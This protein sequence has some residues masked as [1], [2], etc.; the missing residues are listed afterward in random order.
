MNRLGQATLSYVGLMAVIF[1][2]LDD[3]VHSLLMKRPMGWL[4]WSP[5]GEVSSTVRSD[6]INR[7]V[8]QTNTRVKMEL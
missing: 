5:L 8:L 1:S 2:S 6:I 4:Y 3:F 7:E